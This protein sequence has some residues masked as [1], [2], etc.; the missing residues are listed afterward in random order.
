MPTYRAPRGTRD[1]LPDEQHY[2]QHVVAFATELC[3]RHGYQLI[4]TPVFEDARL[5]VRTTG[6][7]TDIVEKEM[8]VFEDRGGDTMALRPEGTAPV[9]RAYLEHGM[10]SLSQPVRLFTPCIP[11]FRYDRPQAGR[12]R[13]FHQLNVEA[14]G[15]ADSAVDAELIELAWKFLTGLGLKGLSLQLN[16]IGDPACRPRYLQELRAYYQQHVPVLCGD[17]KGRF[18]RNTLR[19]LDCKKESCRPYSDAAPKSADHLCEACAQHLAGLQAGLKALGIPY[20]MDHRLVRGLDYYTRTVFEV[21]PQ[22]EGGQSTI[23]GGGR[24]DGLIEALGGRPT[25]GVGFA[26]GLERIILNLQRQSRPA[27]PVPAL[28]KPQALIAHVGDEAKTRALALASALRA[29][30]KSV[31]VGAG[32]KSLKAQLRQAGALQTS[33]VL[34]LGEDEL[35]EGVVT[36]KDMKGGEQHK[37][38][39][40]DVDAIT[41]K[42]P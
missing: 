31:I 33:Y 24:Y 20:A 36:L 4:Q 35:R 29:R 16:S 21:Q 12:Y 9:C 8:Y 5:F 32:G 25:P 30:G 42:L 18:E 34:I 17:C 1:L 14:I 7:E 13:Q 11:V 37:V 28:A 26:A 3:Q 6:E 10:A 40:S 2:W 39:L 22:E 19:L 27:G 41:A 38:A 15:D 23:A